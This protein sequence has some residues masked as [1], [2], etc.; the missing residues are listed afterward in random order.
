MQRGVEVVV[1]AQKELLDVMKEP[2][3]TLH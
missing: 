1:E 2:V 3:Q